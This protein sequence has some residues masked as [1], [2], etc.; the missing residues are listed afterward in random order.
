[1]AER[2]TSRE[3]IE[4]DYRTMVDSILDTEIVMLDPAG[5]ILTWSEGARRLKGYE[6]SE[7]LGK[8]VSMFYDDGDV[9]SGLAER[10]LSQ[11]LEAGRFETEG[12]RVRKGSQRFWAN[13][14]ITPV[15][16]T[17]GKH[18]GF[19]KITRDITERVQREQLLQRQR[20]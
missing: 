7:V 2:R 9:R 6:A 5:C 10:E 14:V 12:W 3:A 8:H 4:P 18:I 15:R 17:E 13:V 11:A 16:D 1:M 20:D 19:V